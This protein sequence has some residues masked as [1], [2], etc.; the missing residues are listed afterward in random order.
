MKAIS[1]QWRILK[2]LM[3]RDMIVRFGRDNIGF[4]WVVLEPMILCLGVMTIWSVIKP[5]YEHGVQVLTFVIT[6]YMPLT[7]FRHLTN[8]AVHLLRRG[9]ELLYHRG[10]THLDLFLAR[11]LLE[12]TATTVALC[13]VYTGLAIVGLAEPIHD[14]SLVTGGWLLQGWFSLGVGACLAAVT[15]AA[16]SA[17]R[18]VQPVQYLSVPLSPVFYMVDWLPAEAQDFMRYNPMSHP[19][20]LIR[21]GV[22]GPSV[23]AQ[24]DPGF[25]FVCGLV[26]LALGFWGI[27]AVKDRVNDR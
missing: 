21:A 11:M 23:Q 2:A 12:F 3:I 1:A 14:I 5:P 18:F 20:E 17:E 4:V 16:E 27:L 24:Y 9:G 6:G 13:A 19:Y 15:E 10:I 8:S 22:F 7:L 25:S 26:L